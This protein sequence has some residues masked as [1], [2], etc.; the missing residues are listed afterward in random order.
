MVNDHKE[1]DFETPLENNKDLA[2]HQKALK[3]LMILNGYSQ[4]FMENLFVFQENV[5]YLTNIQVISN[6]N[7]TTFY[8]RHIT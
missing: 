4:A 6:N 8:E 5:H 3:T 1:S 2:I 7:I